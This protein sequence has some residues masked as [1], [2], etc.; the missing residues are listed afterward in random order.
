MKC[1][2]F[3]DMGDKLLQKGDCFTIKEG[4]HSHVFTWLAFEELDKAYFYPCKKDISIC[5]I[6][7]P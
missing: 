1:I 7:L 5:R 2:F 4:V 6:T 3:L